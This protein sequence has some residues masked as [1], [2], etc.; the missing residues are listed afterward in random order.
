MVL[1]VMYECVEQ[2]MNR[3]RTNVGG[4]VSSLM[5]EYLDNDIWS[6]LPDDLQEVIAP[7]DRKYM[8]GDEEKIYQTKL[9][10]PSASEVF[11]KNCY[12]GGEENFYKQLDYYKDAY[13]RIKRDGFGGRSVYWWLSSPVS[14]A[15]T[16]FCVV[17]NGG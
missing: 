15:A 3:G 1:S 13:H 4:I 10:L 5:Q 12:Y 6:L 11:G 16:A 2:M 7:V 17:T 8:D 9:F 14:S